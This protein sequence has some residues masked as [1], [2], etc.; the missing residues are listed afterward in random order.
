MSYVRS[1]KRFQYGAVLFAL[2]AVSFLA[3][4]FQAEK[5][6]FQ[7][8]S[9]LES[10][11]ILDRNK[12]VITVLPNGKGEYSHYVSELPARF[13]ELLTK[14]EDRFFYVHPGINPVSIMRAVGKSIF[15]KGPGGSSTI[16]QQLAKNLL[17]N[18]RDRTILHKIE[19]LFYT[20]SLEVF[21]SKEQILTMYANTVYMGNNIQGFGQASFDYFG[22]DLNILNDSERVALLATLS[23][24]GVQ[25]PWKA[26][27]KKNAEIVAE[28]L[29]V[30]FDSHYEINM[31]P[32]QYLHR[33]K[34]SFEFDTLNQVCKT[35]CVTTL[36]KDVTERLRTV[37]Q[38]NI[39]VAW[40]SG[41]RNGAIVV[42]KLPENELL[43][44]VGSPDV[45]GEANGHGIN[46]A[47]E[48]R[49]IGSTAKP[50][51]YLE[52]FK[53]GLRP[54]TLVEDREYK[55]QIATGFSLYPKNYDGLYHGTVTLHQALSN[56]Y[57]IPTVKTLEYVG[58]PNF[59][60]FLEQGL[61]FLPL[62]DL[63]SYALGIA[64]GGLEMDPLT[65]AHYFTLFPARGRMKP[66]RLFLQGGTS[67]GQIFTPMGRVE[68]ET[69]VAE[70]K[71]TEL[72]TKILNDRK[73]G[74]EQFGLVSSLNLSQD[75]YAVKTGTSRDY[76][77]SWTVGYTPD[78]VV[79][80]WL[81]NA[82]NEPLKHVSGQSGAGHIWNESMALLI[83]S[84]YNKKT[85]FLLDS[86]RSFPVGN[87]LDFGL[88]DDVISVHQ[89]LMKEDRLILSPH[90]GDMVMLEGSTIIPLRASEA[91]SWFVNGDF[92]DTSDNLDFVPGKTGVY[93][94]KA[95]AE[96]KSETVSITV[97]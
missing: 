56:S 64:L 60:T 21:L 3:V 44:V 95:T 18:E 90:E 32:D 72:V 45:N 43:A 5:S 76:H 85:P 30:S 13:K 7:N 39:E 52:A 29:G 97:K 38:R 9:R 88:P 36:D 68:N 37:L 57:N 31:A 77:D 24:P 14:K 40:D 10:V 55:Y 66:L 75:N 83:N 46:M 79:A 63:D 42:I 89:N 82:E 84:K 93:Q 47:I 62:Q 94:I 28:R 61:H 73:T 74:V 8:Y 2:L 54:Y 23:S 19:E 81:G 78:Y 92:K 65:L 48:P 53:K 71:Y 22:K 87:T 50:F 51:I 35:L 58:L 49:P 69:R 41:G 27:G 91:V 1:S 17:S 16:T 70:P 4:L 25:N 11:L 86:V 80:V 59:Y 20:L 15:G 96:R 12:E 34:T 26:A 67:N 33:T 6:L